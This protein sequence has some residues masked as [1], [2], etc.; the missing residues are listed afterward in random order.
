[1]FQ[2]TNQQ[3]LAGLNAVLACTDNVSMASHGS[4][5]KASHQ[6]IYPVP[7]RNPLLLQLENA[8]LSKNRKVKSMM[9]AP[10]IEIHKVSVS[11]KSDYAEMAKSSKH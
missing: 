5:R 2:T 3:Y 10:D 8:R 1:M 7:I 6:Q 11:V 9:H 4:T